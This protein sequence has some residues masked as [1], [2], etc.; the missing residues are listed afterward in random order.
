M[1]HLQRTPSICVLAL[2]TLCRPVKCAGAPCICSPWSWWGSRCRWPPGRGADHTPAWRGSPPDSRYLQK[3]DSRMCLVTWM[4]KQE[5]QMTR[6]KQ[7][8]GSEL[9]S[10]TPVKH[11]ACGLL[12]H[13]HAVS[14]KWVKASGLWKLCANANFPEQFSWWDYFYVC[15]AAS[16]MLHWNTHADGRPTDAAKHPVSLLLVSTQSDY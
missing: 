15:S 16:R 9:A 13:T 4:C 14:T 5:V 2:L 1:Q 6:L 7:L 11:A 12:A 3:I 10:H 8:H